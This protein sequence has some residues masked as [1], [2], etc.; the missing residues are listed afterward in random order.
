M[1]IISF[2]I[3]YNKIKNLYK[4]III[5]TLL[6]IIEINKFCACIIVQN[7]DNSFSNSSKSNLFSSCKSI[8]L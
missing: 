7:F 2:N 5:F 4:M 3:I 6:N 1:Y 8:I